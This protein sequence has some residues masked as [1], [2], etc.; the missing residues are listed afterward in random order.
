MQR[1]QKDCKTSPP[2]HLIGW[3]Q[4]NRHGNGR[5][6]KL[7]L[8]LRHPSSPFAQPWL[9]LSC[10]TIAPVISHH[11]Q[12]ESEREKNK[13]ETIEKR[14]AAPRC[15]GDLP[16][17]YKALDLTV[18]A[19]EPDIS[20]ALL[21]PRH[22]PY[23][24]LHTREKGEKWEKREKETQKYLFIKTTAPGVNSRSKN[25][26]SLIKTGWETWALTDYQSNFAAE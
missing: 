5:E 3:I 11:G 17:R 10:N 18:R 15:T 12:W 25:I 13:Y 26:D 2:G 16:S 14:R 20:Q 1:K 6:S 7:C 22:I 9:T 24:I 19:L 21:T 4:R 8:S 23:R